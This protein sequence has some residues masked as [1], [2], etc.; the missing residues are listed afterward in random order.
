MLRVN[1]VERSS[2]SSVAEDTKPT[3]LAEPY[4]R[5]GKIAAFSLEYTLATVKFVVS[6]L[7]FVLAA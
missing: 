2:K 6:L 3:I 7:P 4:L 1:S 5:H